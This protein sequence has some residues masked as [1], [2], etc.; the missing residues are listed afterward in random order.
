[1]EEM[2]KKC[3]FDSLEEFNR[4]IVNVDLTSAKKIQIFEDWKK[5]D[6]TKEGLL[7]LDTQD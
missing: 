3:G 2:V 7:K 5:N 4:L 1:M 6:G